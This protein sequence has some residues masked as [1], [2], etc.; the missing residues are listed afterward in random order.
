MYYHVS[1]SRERCRCMKDPK[2]LRA[3]ASLSQTPKW[4]RRSIVLLFVLNRFLL[5]SIVNREKIWVGSS[6]IFDFPGRH[7]HVSFLFFSVLNVCSRIAIRALHQLQHRHC[8]SHI[9]RQLF[10]AHYSLFIHLTALYGVLI[11]ESIFFR[12]WHD[13][14]SAHT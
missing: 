8:V 12:D 2:N 11:P 4:M 7:S 6:L 14:S 13:I 5:Q 3:I 10:S 9:A 1:R